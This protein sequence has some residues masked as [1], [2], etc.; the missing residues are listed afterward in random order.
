MKYKTHKIGTIVLRVVVI[1]ITLAG[2]II[3]GLMFGW[4]RINLPP[5]PIHGLKQKWIPIEF[6]PTQISPAIHSSGPGSI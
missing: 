1:L 4:V 2:I 3:S 5:P 6:F